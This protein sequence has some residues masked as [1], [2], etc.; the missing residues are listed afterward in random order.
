MIRGKA[1]PKLDSPSFGKT[2]G[3]CSNRSPK[4]KH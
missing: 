4:R 3:R 2:Q 1:K